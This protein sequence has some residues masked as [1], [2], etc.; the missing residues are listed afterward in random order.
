[1]ISKADV[2]KL[3]EPQVADHFPNLISFPTD[4]VQLSIAISTKRIADFLDAMY[5]ENDG[6]PA[7]HV[8]D[9]R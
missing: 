5:I 7:L 2:S 6:R 8:R 4:P 1:M 9:L 3:L